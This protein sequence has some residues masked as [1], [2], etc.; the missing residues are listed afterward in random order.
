MTDVMIYVQHLMGIGHQRRMAAIA[1][2]CSAAGLRVTY[3]SGGMPVQHLQLGDSMFVQLPP[4]RSPDLRFDRLVDEHGAEVDDQW[5]DT[6]RDALLAAWANSDASV[7]VVET[8][9]FGR[10][11]MRFELEPLLRAARDDGAV[12]VS[13]IRDVIDYRPKQKKYQVMADAANSWFDHVLVHSDPALVSLDASFPCTS[14]IAELIEYTG[15]VR[16]HDLQPEDAET[17]AK[18]TRDGVDEIVVSAGGGAY[19]QHLLATALDAQPLSAYK[20]RTWR[21]LVGENLPEEAL[22]QLQ[23]RIQGRAVVERARPD[24]RAL[25]RRAAVSVS[26]GGYNTIMDILASRV[27]AVVVAYHDDTEREQL[28]RGRALALRDLIELLPDGELS[29]ARLARAVDA[30]MHRSRPQVAVDVSGA[31]TSARCLARWAGAKNAGAG[32]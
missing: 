13:S 5:R 1:R 26:Q 3:V 11:L 7:L 17:S 21:V 29:P 2:E 14:D 9:P 31:V 8:Y 4:C 19:G 20:N 25:L 23:C 18:T 6:R 27:R 15:F 28:I 32:T 16:E 22:T 30:A 24:F 12:C 10:K